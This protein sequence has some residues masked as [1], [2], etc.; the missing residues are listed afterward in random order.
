[1]KSSAPLLIACVLSIAFAVR[2]SAQ[3]APETR[4]FTGT[5]MDNVCA[6]AGS[7]G[8]MLE[9]MHAKTAQ[10]CTVECVHTGGNYV[11]YGGNIALIYGLDDQTKPEPFAG[12]AVVVTGTYDAAA[13]M[14]HLATIA[15]ATPD[16]ATPAH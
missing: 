10:E 4:T 1:M 15:P 16:P 11:L 14:I 7:H 8:P 2:P 12:Q 6:S 9:K 13:K 5:I 3:N